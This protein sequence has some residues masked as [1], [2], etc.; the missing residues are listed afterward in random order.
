MYVN[1]TFEDPQRTS[2]RTCLGSRKYNAYL[3]KPRISSLRLWTTTCSQ[4]MSERQFSSEQDE[5][6]AD[7]SSG[8]V[9][10]Y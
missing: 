1:G 5:K 8:N 3:I 7:T 9:S 6:F 4:H 2:M 10:K